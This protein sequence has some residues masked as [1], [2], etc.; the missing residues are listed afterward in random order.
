MEHPANPHFPRRAYAERS[1]FLSFEVVLVGFSRTH[2]GIRAWAARVDGSNGAYYWWHL[3]SW[4]RKIQ[5]RSSH[6]LGCERNTSRLPQYG[7]LFKPILRM[8]TPPKA[9]GGRYAV[10]PSYPGWSPG[11]LPWLCHSRV[12][13]MVLICNAFPITLAFAHGA[14]FGIRKKFRIGNSLLLESCHTYAPQEIGVS[15]AVHRGCEAR[16]QRDRVNP[17]RD[18]G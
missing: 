2:W 1:R 3:A 11:A 13:R 9:W 12:K 6:V 16:H 5:A 7:Q 18:K 10:E 4:K 8:T 17:H 15:N 14:V